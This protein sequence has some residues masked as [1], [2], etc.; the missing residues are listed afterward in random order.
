MKKSLKTIILHITT[1]GLFFIGTSNVFSQNTTP[2]YNGLALTPPMGWNTW[3]T[4]F[5]NVN[6]DLIKSVADS[7]VANGMKDAGYEYVVIDDCWQIDRD[8]N[9]VIVVD[10]IRFPSGIKSLA[11][12]IHSK[13]LKLGIYSDAG[14]LTC[15]SKPGSFNYEEIDANTYASW[16]VD[17]VKFDWC[18]TG[19]EVA[20]TQYTKMSNALV[21]TGRPIVFS[22]CE[23]GQSSPWLWAQ[24]VGNLWRA[25]PDIQ[26]C[27]NCTQTWGG[28]GWTLII[29]KVA[30]LSRYSGPG[31]WNDPDMLEVGNTGLSP[32][33]SLAHF[34][35]WCMLGA[36]LM[37]GNDIRTMSAYTKSILTNKELIAI[38]QDSLGIQGRRII[39]DNGLEVWLKPLQDSSKAVT[40]FN[41]CFKDTLITVKWNQI[42][43][44]DGNATVRNLWQ[45]TD[46][47]VYKDSIQ[48]KV[49][50][51]SAIVLKIKG[52]IETVTDTVLT[53]DNETISLINGNSV[54]LNARITPFYLETDAKVSNNSLISIKQLGTNQYKIT[55]KAVGSCYVTIATTDGKIIDTCYVTITSAELPSP[56]K[57]M[58]IGETISSA[59][60]ENGT[61]KLDASGRDINDYNDQCGF[62][63]Q[64][65]TG[66]K[67]LVCRIIS[68]TN[69]NK[70]AKSGIMF[71]DPLN[72]GSGFVLLAVNP[73]NQLIFEWR[74]RS[75][76]WAQEF[77]IDTVTT[78]IYLKLEKNNLTFNAYTS[79]DGITWTLVSSKKFSAF[80]TTYTAGL[81]CVSHNSKANVTAEFDNV[82]LSDL[83]IVNIPR[84]YQEK[85]IGVTIYPNPVNSNS[86][87]VK[88]NRTNPENTYD[89]IIYTADGKLVYS[90]NINANNNS[91]EIDATSANLNNG[92]YHIVI[93]G[94]RFSGESTFIV[95]KTN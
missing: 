50:Y 6:E 83:S 41:R 34:S 57:L 69:P 11:D 9:G 15:Q 60:F 37:A 64:N 94:G 27:W 88:L 31:H 14:T 17:Y 71:R 78:P 4:F 55:A 76:T 20:Q 66:N 30:D 19:N 85:T 12:Y 36:P 73:Q 1:I 87:G 33:E 40:F 13:G 16:G 28:Q 91:F 44:L 18:F 35:I 74:L 67:S 38:N 7:M 5:C 49:P 92:V 25:T 46:L 63:Q 95:N 10:P 72:D 61:F 68:Q 42:G 81:F 47:G 82:S 23:W 89:V 29:D 48:L 93:K 39:S 58:T 45:H 53:L 80:S 51:H 8:A 52:D 59:Y 79:F 62:I 86:I 43:L 24:S 56:W 77:I 54:F 70:T 75:G 3:N 84:L 21:A 26:A 2:S 22:I 32:S 65:T 90:N